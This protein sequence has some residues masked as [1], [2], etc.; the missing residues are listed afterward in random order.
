[1][2]LMEVEAKHNTH[3]LESGSPTTTIQKF[4]DTSRVNLHYIGIVTQKKGWR[5][6]AE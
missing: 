4:V 5:W 2:Q 3:K 6:K 1:M